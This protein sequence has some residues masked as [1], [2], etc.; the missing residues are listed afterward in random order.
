MGDMEFN[1]TP[2]EWDALVK[3]NKMR[4]EKWDNLHKELDDALEEEFGSEE[5]EQET[6]TYTEAAKKEERIFNSTMMSKQE[7][8]E[9]AAANL[10]DPNL[11][12]TDNWIAGAK[13]QAERMYSE[14]EV[15]NIVEEAR[16][17]VPATGNPR[18]FTKNFDKWFEQFK[19]K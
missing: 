3:R 19:K 4:Q 5:P 17:Q 1:G 9:E 7:T 2:E 11:C 6:L 15:K 10:A 14:E 13:Y 12:K 16:W 8:L 18:E